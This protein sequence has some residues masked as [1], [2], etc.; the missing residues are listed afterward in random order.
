MGLGFEVRG[1]FQF[2]G[3]GDVKGEVDIERASR[4]SPS[5]NLFKNLLMW[6]STTGYGWANESQRKRRFNRG[7]LTHERR[8]GI[9]FKNANL[10]NLFRLAIVWEFEF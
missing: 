7:N 10:I 1:G 5:L 6:R 2:K 3:G 4:P 8:L 9:F